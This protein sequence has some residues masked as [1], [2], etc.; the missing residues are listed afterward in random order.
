M[1]VAACTDVDAL[2][3]GQLQCEPR[4]RGWIWIVYAA[5]YAVA[6]PW[7]W[8][9]SFRGPLVLGLPLWAAVS[10]LGVV[11]LGAWTTFVISRY[12]VDQQEAN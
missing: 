2:V 9:A 11:A 10:L 12:W 5:L 1:P 3:A 4:K 6:I 7:Y 8:P